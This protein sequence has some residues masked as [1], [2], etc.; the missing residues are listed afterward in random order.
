M[1]TADTLDSAL[2]NFAPLRRSLIVSAALPAVAI[3]LL[4]HYGMPVLQAILWSSVFPL[5]TIAADWRRSRR[6]DAIATLVLALLA[7]SLAMTAFGGD[8]RLALAKDSALTGVAGLIFLGSLLARRP[9]IF[10]VSR[11]YMAGATAA[12]WEDRWAA[13]PR[14]RTTMRV[15]TLV[16]GLGLL[17]DSVARI[18]LAYTIS[19]IAVAAISPVIALVAFG[20]LIAFTIVYVRWVRA[21]Y[22][23]PI[24]A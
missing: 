8:A 3:Q 4:A 2:P 10:F 24:A 16:W 1:H 20:G 9:L 21:R 22:A 19:P 13:R 15:I 12:A 18:V 7:L 17:G 14:F 5:V 6:L 11:T 23:A